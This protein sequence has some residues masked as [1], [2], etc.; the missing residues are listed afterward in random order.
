MQQNECLVAVYTHG[1]AN[2]VELERVGLEPDAVALA[3]L[4]VGGHVPDHADTRHG[5]GRRLAG[6]P[7]DDAAAGVLAELEPEVARHVEP[8]PETPHRLLR[9]RHGHQIGR[10][11][12][13][14]SSI[15]SMYALLRSQ[16]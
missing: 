3:A 13:L 11:A 1:V 12:G 8:E 7:G 15:S 6:A 16:P 5:D 4:D 10:P 2:L 9:R 14:R